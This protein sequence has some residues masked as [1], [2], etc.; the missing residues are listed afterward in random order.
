LTGPSARER[1]EATRRA[2]ELEAAADGPLVGIGWATVDLERGLTELATALGT[3]PE[4]FL[5]SPS[6]VALGARCHVADGALGGGVAVVI[7]E[8][9]TEGRLAG[10]LARH[11][12]GPAVIWHGA[13]GVTRP[14]DPLAPATPGPFGPERPLSPAPGRP[15][16]LRF[17][18]DVS[19]GTIRT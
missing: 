1:L 15:D 2:V 6:S 7:L 16:L 17:I 5:E 4:A 9:S 14:G 13:A 18:V 10:R 3:V 8:P 12:E 19:P 11:D